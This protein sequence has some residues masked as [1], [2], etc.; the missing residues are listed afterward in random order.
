MLPDG[1]FNTQLFDCNYLLMNFTKTF[2]FYTYLM[3][4]AEFSSWDN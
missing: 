2:C 3:V 4:I 1:K